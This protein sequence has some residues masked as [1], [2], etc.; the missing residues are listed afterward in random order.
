ML[1]PDG[2]SYE[3]RGESAER[4]HAL[5][6]EGRDACRRGEYRHCVGKGV[7]RYRER[8][9]AYEQRLRAGNA[10]PNGKFDALDYSTNSLLILGLDW[11]VSGAALATVLGNA[12]AALSYSPRSECTWVFTR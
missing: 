4:D 3:G 12:A 8:I 10:L 5:D 7:Q 2:E 9:K 11:G 1:F 6:R